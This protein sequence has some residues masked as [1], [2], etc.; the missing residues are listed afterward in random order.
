MAKRA[1]QLIEKVDKMFLKVDKCHFER[2]EKSF[3]FDSL[4]F[5][6]RRLLRNDKSKKVNSSLIVVKYYL[7][8][9][10]LSMVLLLLISCANQLPPGGG[11]L[12]KIPPTITSAYPDNET[13]NYDKDFIELEFS[14]YVDKR[15]FKEALFISPAI[16]EQLEINWSGTSVEIVFPNG[17][18]DSLT[19]VVTI[20]T[21]VVDV[22]N[23]N[24]MA[25]SYTFSF[26]T[27]DKIDKRSIDGKVY[28]NDIEGTLIFA[29]KFSEDTSKYLA[30][31]PNY[32]SQIGKDGSYKLNGLAES[33]YRVFAVNDQYRD[34]LYQADQD[35]IGMPDQNISLIGADSTYHGLDFYLTKIDTLKPRILSSVM[36]DKYHIVVTLSEECDSLSYQAANFEIIDSTSNK[37]IPVEYSYQGKSKKEEF[38]LSYKSQLNQENIYYLIAKELKDFEGNVFKN[39]LSG[40]VV[41]DKPDTT[42]PK[43]Y[44]TN[45]NQKSFTDFKNPEILF[46]FDDAITDKE[47]INAIQFSD[48][49][50]GTIAFNESFFDDATL[51]IKPKKDLKPETVYE[52]KIDLSKFNDAAGNKVDSIYTFKFSTITGVEFTGLSGKVISN[53]E[54]LVIVLQDAKN[55]KKFF[56]VKPDKTSTYS[57]ERIVAGIYSLWIYS[58]TDS[59]K[60]F[61][62][63]YPDPFKYAEEFYFVKDTLQ[64]RP[65][66]S[67][68]DFDI[69][70][71]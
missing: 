7:L 1:E 3:P 30:K 63:G 8:S 19:Y 11:E 39:E 15:S 24:R 69:V 68:T 65:R 53:K 62:K 33:V 4:R 31:K 71:E 48:T 10:F 61:S 58:D 20:G 38:I 28:G 2:R 5:L 45:P 47:I 54:N 57:F 52:I 40:L 49:T 36:T 17:L 51:S 16:D 55:N 9:F 66:W 56:T 42:A 29:Y 22:N 6:N 59:T 70:F 67:V 37:N 13:I 60:T 14:E 32:I 46:Y 12:D 18:K 43:L 27:C 21:D 25:D 26:A 35:L 23:K 34:F 64:L 41:T 50:R 44:R